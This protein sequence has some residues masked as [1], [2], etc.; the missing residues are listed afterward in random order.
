MW[1]GWWQSVEKHVKGARTIT[2]S[3]ERLP[4]A[5]QAV[6]CLTAPSAK[7]CMQW[8]LQSCTLPLQSWGPFWKFFHS[9]LCRAVCAVEHVKSGLN[10][11]AISWQFVS[12]LLLWLMGEQKRQVCVKENCHE[13]AYL[14]SLFLL[15]PSGPYIGVSLSPLAHSTWRLMF[16]NKKKVYRCLS[17]NISDLQNFSSSLMR[18]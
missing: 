5:I 3:S 16:L 18:K 12:A 14:P 13:I 6:M 15:L 8:G 2:L 9:V 1:S 4:G 17:K 10:T 11:T 7:P